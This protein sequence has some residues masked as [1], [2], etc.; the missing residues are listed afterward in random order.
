[1][2]AGLGKRCSNSLTTSTKPRL[3]L[4]SAHI[5]KALHVF[6]VALFQHH[7]FGVFIAEHGD[8][9]NSRLLQITK[10]NDVAKS[11]G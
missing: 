4:A 5:G 10:S 8:S 3:G 11:L 9:V 7:V 1:M 2:A 6:F